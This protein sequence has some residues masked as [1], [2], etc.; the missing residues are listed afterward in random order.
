MIFEKKIVNIFKYRFFVTV[1]KKK[2]IT[3]IGIQTSKDYFCQLFFR[4]K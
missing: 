2:S 3:M 4:K 1:I